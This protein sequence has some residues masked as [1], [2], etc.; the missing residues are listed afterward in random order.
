MPRFF[1]HA[2]FN[3]LN[4]SRDELGLNF[5]DVETARAEAVWAAKDGQGP[6]D[7]AGW[8]W[9]GMSSNVK[10]SECRPAPT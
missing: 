1:F 6:W 8:Y 9:I 2:H 4:R 3:H 5:P 10:G 7:I